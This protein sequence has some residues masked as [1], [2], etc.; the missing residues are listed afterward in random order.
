MKVNSI[1]LSCI[2]AMLILSYS[3]YILGCDSDDPSPTMAGEMMAGDMVAGEMMAGDMMAGEVMAGDMVAGDM[4][5][6]DMMAGDMM[7]GDMMAGDMMTGPICRGGQN[8]GYT[9][10][11]STLSLSGAGPFTAPQMVELSDGTWMISWLTAIDES[12]SD[13]NY[14]HLQHLDADF[15]AQGEAVQVARAKGGQYKLHGTS[16]GVVLVWVNQRS[17]LL[18]NEGVYLQTFDEMGVA[19]NEPLGVNQSFNVTSIHSAWADGFGGIL[20]MSEAQKISA[21]TFNQMGLASAP[22]VLAQSNNRS[23]VVAFTGGGWSVAWLTRPSADSREYDISVATLNDQGEAISEVRTF[24]EVKASGKLSL[25]YGNGIYSMAWT[26]PDPT[27]LD[28]LPR[29]II[30]MRLLD[31]TLNEI[32]RFF[33]MDGTT[34]LTL[35]EVSWVPPSLFAISWSQSPLGGAESILGV[36]R[37]NQLG[38]V[39]PSVIVNH[40]EH[41]YT[42]LSLRGNASAL[43]A[44]FTADLNP[45]PTGLFSSETVVMTAPIAPCEE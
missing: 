16:N 5:A 34:D 29:Q 28:P 2:R 38:Q 17:E 19:Q 32:G 25:A 21:I 37:I 39:L 18:N 33:V 11:F 15:Q 12:P 9:E 36:S 24:S 35:H 22:E 30:G 31:E 4:V 27:S 14:L 10:D 43:R 1:P 7:A 13:I 8:Y 6:G 20:V 3:F 42:E 26:F 23:P 44:L 40:E 45:Q 41:L